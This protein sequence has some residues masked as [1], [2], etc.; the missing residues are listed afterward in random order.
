[1]L[2]RFWTYLGGLIGG[3]AITKAPI[4][5]LN[6]PGLEPLFDIVGAITML[7]FAG[8]LVVRGVRVMIN[9]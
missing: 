7:V 3:Y 1:M 4:E 2:D 6:I 5:G 8:A 9:K